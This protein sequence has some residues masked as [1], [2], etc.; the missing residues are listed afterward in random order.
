MPKNHNRLSLMLHRATEE[1]TRP[2]DLP[3]KTGLSKTTCWRLERAGDFP[4]R[5][6][7]SAGAVGYRTAEIET[8]L[9]SRQS[10]GV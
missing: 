6:Q 4:K 3:K 2:R 7:L 5:I 10:A 9:V 1:I 8:W